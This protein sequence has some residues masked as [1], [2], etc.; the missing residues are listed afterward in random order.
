VDRWLALVAT[1]HKFHSAACIADCGTAL[2]VDALGADGSHLGG[3]IAPGTM[4]MHKALAV[5]TGIQSDHGGSPV[6][7]AHNTEDGINAGARL[8]VSGCINRIAAELHARVGTMRGVITG[9]DA[10][11]IRPWLTWSFD[12]VPNLVIEGLA[13]VAEA[14]R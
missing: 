11:A 10:E 3:V 14:E 1:W 9:G 13:I 2:T 8:A 12:R 4:L 5:N 6:I 7:F